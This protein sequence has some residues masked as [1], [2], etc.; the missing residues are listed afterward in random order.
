MD[1]LEVSLLHELQPLDATVLLLL[2]DVLFPYDGE[3][4]LMSKQRQHDQVGI[5]SVEHMP[6]VGIIV[7]R[8]S[9]LPDV[10]EH[11]VFTFSWHRSVG[12]DH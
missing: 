7:W 9:H 1:Q 4:G 2:D 3:V 10:V 6:R 12:Q 5:R 8:R 11:L